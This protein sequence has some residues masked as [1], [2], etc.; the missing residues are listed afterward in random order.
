MLLKKTWLF[1]N[2]FANFLGRSPRFVKYW[3]SNYFEAERVLMTASP[4]NQEIKIFIK[5]CNTFHF[6]QPNYFNPTRNTCYNHV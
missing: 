6:R 2:G 5:I 4:I 1:L 3:K